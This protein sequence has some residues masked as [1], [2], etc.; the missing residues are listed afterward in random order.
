[1]A[2]K[3]KVTKPQEQK[4]INNLFDGATVSEIMFT[5]NNTHVWL[6]CADGFTR[7]FSINTLPKAVRESL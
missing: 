7:L 6:V 2:K 4:E 5:N 1:M 3:T